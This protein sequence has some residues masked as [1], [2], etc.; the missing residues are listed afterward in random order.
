MI[1][2]DER[3]L[4]AKRA[5]HEALIA[6]DPTTITIHRSGQVNDGI[7]GVIVI[8]EDLPPFTG[9]L[10]PESSTTRTRQTD[11]G[12]VEEQAWELLAPADADISDAAG[13][14]DEFDA[15]GKRFRVVRVRPLRWKAQVYGYQADC[16]AL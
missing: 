11:V 16:V 13:V 4:A 14:N 6:E 2:A 8:D 7:G 1:F 5:A 15:L 9:R 10:L 3:V 12:P